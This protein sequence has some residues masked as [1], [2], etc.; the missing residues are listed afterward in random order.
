MR[1]VR[2]HERL[3]F[4]KREDQA[5][6]GLGNTLSDWVEQFDQRAGRKWL[7]GRE[8]VLASRLQGTQPVIFTVRKSAQADQI[9]PDWMAEDRTTGKRYNVREVTESD[10]RQYIDLLCESGVALG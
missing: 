1:H 3:R 9:C 4:Y 6:D 10:T 7:R 2:L 5:D 8:E